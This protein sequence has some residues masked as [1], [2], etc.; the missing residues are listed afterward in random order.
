MKIEIAAEAVDD[1]ANALNYVSARSEQAA[2][3]L[4]ARI[5][6]MMHRLANRDF[7]GP[8]DVL[9]GDGR[10]RS[11]RVGAYRI[12]YQRIDDVFRV[13]RVYHHARRPIVK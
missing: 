4:R 5:V 3:R 10:A 11:W 7:E 6:E 8:E 1:I 12:Y 2:E 9:I 13:L